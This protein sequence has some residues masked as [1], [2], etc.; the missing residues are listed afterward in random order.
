MYSI[1]LYETTVRVYGRLR[2]WRLLLPL[3]YLHTRLDRSIP[4]LRCVVCTL[5]WH[6]WDGNRIRLGLCWALEKSCQAV[7]RE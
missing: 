2:R 5:R 4:L 6:A 3:L 7:Y 1:G